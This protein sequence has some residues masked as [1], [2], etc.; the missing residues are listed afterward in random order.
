LH[1]DV[2]IGQ[3]DEQ[4]DM[5]DPPIQTARASTVQSGLVLKSLPIH[6]SEPGIC[7]STVPADFPALQLSTQG[8]P[9]LPA[10][11]PVPAKVL[12]SQALGKILAGPSDPTV[13]VGLA[14]QSHFDTCSNFAPPRH[15]LPGP[16]SVPFFPPDGRMSSQ[17]TASCI[18]V[19]PQYHPRRLRVQKSSRS[20][21]QRFSQSNVFGQQCRLD[22]ESPIQD[23]AA[24]VPAGQ[25]QDA[26]DQNGQGPPQQIPPA[27]VVD[28]SNRLIRLGF[29]IH[30]GDFDVL[31]RT[32]YIDHA[33]IRRWTA[34][35][36]LQLVGPPTGW[37]Q[38]FSS[39]WVDQI[40]PDEWFDVTIIH[41]DPPRGLANSYVVFDVIVSQS[42]QLDR[43]AG[44]VTVMSNM[45][46]SFDTFS[47]AAS[48]EPRVSGFDIAQ[49]ADAAQ[50]CRYQ[51]C[52]V[53]FGWNEIPYT[54]RPQHDMSHGDGFQ[55]QIRALPRRLTAA[56]SSQAGSSTDVASVG[57]VFDV[58]PPR[59]PA[60]HQGNATVNPAFMTPLH[61]FQMNGIEVVVELVN[62]QLAQPTHA[63]ATALQVPFNCIEALHI[64]P[65][66]PDG[67]PELAIPAIVQRVGDV[68]LHSTDR[69]IMIDVNYHHHPNAAGV[70][71][72]PTLVRG[73]HRVTHQVTRQQIL[74]KAAV[75][76]YCEF[77][78]EGCAV[79]LDGLL[80]PLTQTDPRPVSHGSYATVD[81]P[82]PYGHQV[83]TQLAAGTLHHDGTTDAMM[84]FMSEPMD[85]SDDD[86][87]LAQLYAS[88]KVVASVVKQRLRW[89][90]RNITLPDQVQS[91]HPPV[92]QSEQC[93][94]D[95]SET[96]I[97]ETS[98]Q[99]SKRLSVVD[100]LPDVDKTVD[101]QLDHHPSLQ[102]AEVTIAESG[103]LRQP[104]QP[105]EN[106]ARC[107]PLSSCCQDRQ[108]GD[109]QPTMQAKAKVQSTLGYFFPKKTET[110]KKT[111]KPAPDPGQQKITA[112]FTPKPSLQTAELAPTVANQ[113]AELST[114]QASDVQQ[115]SVVVNA[116]DLSNVNIDHVCNS[117]PV[118]HKCSEEQETGPP[119]YPVQIP[120]AQAAQPQQ[121][122]PR[123]A[124]RL[125]LS[126]LFDELATVV[127]R[128][129]GPVMQVEVWYVHHDTH[130]ECLAP[131]IVEL[132]AVQELWY[133]DLCNVW[134]DRI[135]RHQPMRVVNVLPN[136]PYHAHPR[137]AVH[138]ILE[139]GFSPQLVA[140][141]FTAIFLG[142]TRVGLFQRVES[143]PSRI[144]TR[145][146]ILKHGFQLQCDFRPCNM[147]SGLLRFHMHE[148][149]EIFSGI[150]AVLSIAPPPPEPTGFAPGLASASA[151]PL[152]EDQPDQVDMMQRGLIGLG[153][154]TAAA[155]ADSAQAIP[156]DHRMAP[157][158]LSEFRA[159]LL[160][161]LRRT[162]ES[163]I[164][165][166]SSLQVHSWYLNS[167][168]RTRTE[169]FRTVS[170][171]PHQHAW[172]H[173]I[174][175]RWREMLDIRFPV[176]LFVVMPNPPGQTMEPEAHVILLQRPNPLWRAA[177]LTVTQPDDP[178][179]VQFICAMLDAQTSLEQLAFI[180]GV[181]HPS[182]PRAHML[183]I[184]T[185][186]G[187]ATLQDGSTYPVRNGF[188][189][190]IQAYRRDDLNAALGDEVAH[191]Q[192]GFKAIRRKIARLHTHIAN[193][194]KTHM[195]P[196][197]SG[198]FPVEHNMP[199]S[200]AVFPNAPDTYLEPTLALA[201]FTALQAL[202]QPI[203]LL[204]PPA[205]T[206]WVPVVT[207]YLDHVRFPQC[208]QPR[209][210]LLD[211]NPRN[212]IQRMRSAWNDAVAPQHIM[213]LHL[214]Q[215]APADMPAHI[216]AHILIVQQPI[217]QFRSVLISCFDSGTPNVPVTRHATMAPTPVAFQTVLAL[218]YHET[219]CQQPIN[220][221]AVWVGEDELLPDRQLPLIDGHAL[222]VALHRHVYPLPYNISIWDHQAP[223]SKPWAP[224]HIGSHGGAVPGV[225]EFSLGTPLPAS[226]SVP[227]PGFPVTL[228]LDAVLP[229]VRTTPKQ[230]WQDDASAIAWTV[231]P[232]WSQQVADSLHLKLAPVPKDLQLTTPTSNA[233]FQAM[234]AQLGP[235]ELVE[236]YVDGATSAIGAGWSIV[237]VV[238]SGQSPRLL[239]TL[240]G[241]VIVNSHHPLWI[242][243]HTVDNIAA[244]LS[245]LLAAL[246]AVLQFQFTCPVHIRPDLSL[247]RLIAQELVTTVSNPRLAKL[248]RVLAA[249][250]PP[251]VAIHEVRGHTHD[252][253]NDLADSMA[254]HVLQAPDEFP[255][256]SFGD[257]HLLAQETHDLE[258]T[259]TQQMPL[260]FLQCLPNEV[261][262]SV[263]QFPES[264]RDIV[265]PK[266]H[267][268][269][270]PSHAKF[271]CHMAT[272]NVLAL[273]RTD[274]QIEVG[275]RK[276]ARTMRLD[277]QLHAGAVHIA[278]LQ[279]TRTHEG[280]YRSEHYTI[281]SSGGAGKNSERS[282][283][284]LWLNRSL[285]FLHNADGSQV[286][287]A[288]CQCVVAFADPRRLFV[289]IECAHFHMTAVVLHAPCLGKANGDAKAPIEEIRQ[290]W[291][292]TANIWHHAVATDLICVFVDA[293]ATLASTTTE[294]FQ[295]H[296]SD[297]TTAQSLIF[298]D[299]L[300]EHQL[301]VP[302][303]FAALHSGPSFTWTHSSGKRMRLDYVLLSAKLFAMVDK[304]STWTSYDGTFTHEDHIPATMQLEGWL[305]NA[306][307]ADKHRWDDLALLDPD[308]CNA[309]QAALATLPLPPW[310]VK[311]DAHC[312]L[313]EQQLLQLA[314]QFFTKKLGSKRRPT[315]AKQTLETIAF[316]RH[317]LDCGRAWELMTDPVFK[318]EL[319]IVERTVRR[320]VTNDLQVMFDQILVHLQDAGNLSDHKQMF[321]MLVRLGCRRHKSPLR[322]R[323]LPMLKTP[324]GNTVTAFAQQQQLWLQQFAKTE[325]GLPLSWV[326]L[327]DADSKAPCLDRDIQEAATFPSDWQLQAAVAKLK[328]GRAPGPNGLTPCILKAGGS[329]F[330]KQLSTIT[331]KTVA[332]GKEP[333]TW[334]GVRLVPLYKGKDSTSDPA[335]YRAIYISD[336]TSK[337]YHR[338][339]RQQLEGPW[340]DGM[341]LMQFGGRKS[342][343]TDI[344]HHMLEAHQFW[345][346]KNK[347]P[348]AIVFFDFR[349]AFYSVL[350]QALTAQP[351]GAAPLVEALGAWGV[352]KARIEAWL[353]QADKD[354][355]ILGVS[356]HTE[357]LIHD[358]MSNTFFTVDGVPEVCCTTR[359]TRPGDPL[360]DL[361]FNLIMRLVLKDMHTQIQSTSSAVWI[362][363]PQ[364][365]E[366]F[367]DAKVVPTCAYFDVSFVDDAAIAIH[368]ESLQEVE[369]TIQLVVEAFHNAASTRGLDV[370]FSKG[371]TEVLWD[372]IGKG[373]RALK[374][375][376]HD[377]GQWLIWDTMDHHFEL[378]VSHSYKHL[379]SWMQMGGSHQREIAHRASLALQS[380]GCL[381]RTFYHKKYVGM[382]A[383]TIAFQSLSMSRLMYNA[384][385][386][387][388]I[389][390][391]HIAHWQQKLRKPIGLMA[392]HL[393]KGLSPLKID[394]VDLFALSGILPPSDQLQI[395]R[396]R[397]LKRL[398]AYCPQG[399]WNL[400]FHA[401]EFPCS[402]LAQCQASF[403]WF[404][405][406][407]QV[408]GAPEDSADL[409]AWLTYIALDASWKGRLK[410]AAKGCLKFRQATA[411]ENV[412]LRDFQGRFETAGGVIPCKQ[413]T[414]AETWIC[415]Q[416]QKAFASKRA[417]ATHAGRA[418]GYRRLVKFY[419]VDTICN[420]CAKA[421][422]TRK[423]LIEHLRDAAECLQTLQACFPPLPDEQVIALDASDHEITLVLRAQGWG[424]AKAL[425]PRRKL[426]G[427]CLPPAGTPEASAMLAKWTARVPLVGSGYENLQGH[428]VTKAETSAPRV[429]LFADDMPS[430]VFQSTAG[431]NH[432]DGRFSL[433]GLARETA[434]LHIRAQVFVH[435][436]SGFRRQADLHDLLE[437]HV[438]PQGHQIFVLSVD[439]CLQRERGDLASSASL[440]WWM[441]RI[442]SGLVCEAGGGPPCESYS[443]ARLLEGGPPPVRSGKWPNGIPNIPVRAWRQVLIGSRLMRFIVDVFLLLAM[444]GGCAFIEHPQY[445]LWAAHRDPSSVWTSLPMR[446][447]KTL[448]AV[449][450]TSFDQCIF[451]CRAKKPTTII[452]LRLPT[453]R[454]AILGT[455]RM[456]RCHHGSASHE[457][458]AGQESDGAFKT[459]RGKVY[460]PGLNRAI[461]DAIADFVQATFLPRPEATLPDDFADLVVKDFVAEDVV[462]PDY[463]T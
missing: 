363:S 66:P 411:E 410:T 205:L 396:L 380:W 405:Q 259:W 208:F 412:W 237:V 125:H 377:Q 47:V 387:T 340:N 154:P 58:P 168:T 238:Y 101:A 202:W 382:K 175:E 210:V 50:L 463:Y 308:R 286:T 179:H 269:P 447:L 126:N 266:D 301:F 300:C 182:N 275:R 361:L 230:K 307:P 197:S 388:G 49:A 339:L 3:V 234:E 381:A 276:G 338:M 218:A 451:G 281:L 270:A 448:A 25:Q 106:T 185:T 69:L 129:T 135:H 17:P 443:A 114:G 84:D 72:R 118:Q 442:Q 445:P 294:Y 376:L 267:L 65:T 99:C 116:D 318:E 18:R 157:A 59:T 292:D 392:K 272:I 289:K 206:A 280:Q 366:S 390:E 12:S 85:W 224:P 15:A 284:E 358:C 111:A 4:V 283:C 220:E 330:S 433:R 268:V 31:L 153:V 460:P 424:A 133:A 337:L 457:A 316:K 279:E 415:D 311:V 102:H 326:A 359:G 254:K 368:A 422:A 51:E 435:F 180:S 418:H 32:W 249:W 216:A 119:V 54:M 453:L 82:F 176:Y 417:L 317:M 112:F 29:D 209:M 74:F 374:E 81:V 454:H 309:F 33:T 242:G 349:A 96:T 70:L 137:T 196:G 253:W 73:I 103:K 172:H 14:V 152:Q 8:S 375:R 325:A 39:I 296:Q 109:P 150:S 362:G 287:F 360:G 398:L 372:I 162:P 225:G 239:G 30:S 333:S 201:F 134:M 394:T 155:P 28:L 20:D 315:L 147:H 260:S 35:R 68:D 221:C 113:Q 370:N 367:M 425:E 227:C 166:R 94:T 323:P 117:Q 40:N 384:H 240:A 10:K 193:C 354:H 400:L 199:L 142:G 223:P 163:C 351:L 305:P 63:L 169:D 123:P 95:H 11:T 19:R 26:N 45:Q 395:A 304:S 124:W 52:T 61:V 222:V 241:P 143:S 132:D 277:H 91:M 105:C 383:K 97:L 13:D 327:R 404:L 122:P 324:Q 369:S 189:F 190:D 5:L 188:W 139:Q 110:T 212:W 320:L 437:H 248:C 198:Q 310:E 291:S 149:E 195:G 429:V 170:L 7:F 187:Q 127:H 55:V 430:F 334:K 462:Q 138:V 136:P 232:N 167:D 145:D 34:P 71:D 184:E 236:V 313:Y 449:G 87:F 329:V 108:S 203:S 431:F 56:S 321:K 159:T 53:T 9:E 273:D 332:H 350:R 355:A 23:F 76:H 341:D 250:M 416:C 228:S 104:A 243:A 408:P 406:F 93:Q 186:Q 356:Q 107:V 204:Q 261:Q 379:G 229:L 263:W 314:K 21:I 174:I 282:G 178:W 414:Q 331:T 428:S 173:E 183:R 256:V 347:L 399:L 165:S 389:T 77:L 432:G 335:A 441:D 233:I 459:A 42:L 251:E 295:T 194:P 246:A 80:W 393:L 156:F 252:P 342:M 62:A 213:Q 24:S 181:T 461:S 235:Y 458:L 262:E 226:V 402:W 344:A 128:E 401:K 120:S 219:V 297:A 2:L 92:P 343:G 48:F 440:A 364:N 353:T 290:W 278:G 121:P 426:Y 146:M 130:P 293:N 346:R 386:W 57:P 439:M 79:S 403:Q 312:A 1:P 151:G 434:R 86:T 214:V 115:V 177:L 455:G 67:F 365:C 438:F 336:H 274:S 319:K 271:H 164:V 22:H 413:S 191:I 373:S 158:D 456:G 217:P 140:I 244:E 427:P 98:A 100:Q 378:R 37:E 247:S 200:V 6:G 420:A 371:K 255:P 161:Q 265:L 231:S 89:C 348:S 43:F 245:A 215:P 419:A 41:P 192:L 303:T 352:P 75:Y 357:Q 385:T 78:Q 409:Q 141:H 423:R 148:P 131:R 450:V 328:R 391:D 83:D 285:P 299:F 144:C 421:F 160:W 88:K 27:F 60:I 407:Y 345:C 288:D 306:A 44:L 258:W 36:N 90:C 264:N 64:M 46:G 452:H 322:A 38:Q 211:N 444:T 16:A 302:A 171:S 207:W 298:E 446:L 257:L 436:Y 397:Y